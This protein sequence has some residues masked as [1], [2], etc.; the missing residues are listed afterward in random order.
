MQI[1]EQKIKGVFLIKPKLF[2][3]KRGIFRR[4]FCS[5]TLDSQ[6]I[7]SKVVQENITVNYKK[8]TLRG[9]HYQKKPYEEDKTVT[10]IKGEIYDVVLDLRKSSKTYLSWQSCTLSEKN[11]FIIH[12]PKG[13]AHAYL[14]LKNNTILKYIVSKEYNPSYEGGVNYLDPNFKFR[15]PIKPKIISNKDKKLPFLNI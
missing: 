1:K 15:W 5:L 14:T 11:K 10:C 2:E 7:N 9:F 3:D 6:K 12:I 13:C 4:S 8:G